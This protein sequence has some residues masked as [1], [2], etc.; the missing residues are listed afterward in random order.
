MLSFTAGPCFLLLTPI[1]LTDFMMHFVF[2]MAGSQNYYPL[3]VYAEGHCLLNM[4][5]A[6]HFGHFPQF[7]IMN[8]VTSQLLF[9][10]RSVITSVLNQPVPS[11]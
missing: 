4:L 10:Q 9:C 3:I 11:G 8:C 7:D 2:A 5:L 1:V 6:V